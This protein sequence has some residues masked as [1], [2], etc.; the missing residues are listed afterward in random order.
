MKSCLIYQGK[1]NR[2]V[3]INIHPKAE[4][5]RV[6]NVLNDLIFPDYIENQE[7]IRFAVL[8][9]LN[10]SLRA[11]RER[12]VN[13]RIVTTFDAFNDH[14]KISI[15]DFGGGFNPEILPYSLDESHENIDSQAPEFLE[16][17]K[18]HNY[19]R[20]GMGILLAK[21]TFPHFDLVF[22]DIN[23]KPVPWNSGTICGTVINLAAPKKPPASRPEL[24]AGE[25]LN[26]N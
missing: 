11:H 1:K 26:V 3:K 13:K 15:K 24:Q 6:L 14:L 10:N 20:F 9:L 21:K 5:R 22:F 25:R 8:E 7:N 16:Y 23:E 2:R 4:F 19:L 17:Q 18:K 12:Q